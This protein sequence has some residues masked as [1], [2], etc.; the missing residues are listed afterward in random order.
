MHKVEIQ[1]TEALQGY[2]IFFHSFV[3]PISPVRVYV[4]MRMS[5][6]FDE[7]GQ[8]TSDFF[9]KKNSPAPILQS[10]KNVS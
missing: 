9:A 2:D 4:S 8:W 1:Y 6:L 7:Y 10:L 5:T 3:K